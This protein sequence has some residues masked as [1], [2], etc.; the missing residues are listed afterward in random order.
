MTAVAVAR[1]FVNDAKSKIVSSV[2]GSA[3]AG[4]PSSPGSPASLREPKAWWKTIL[5]PCPIT[6]TAPGSLCAAIASFIS[7]DTVANSGA[8]AASGSGEPVTKSG[9]GAAAGACVARALSLTAVGAT[10]PREQAAA[11]V[12][13][14]APTAMAFRTDDLPNIN[15]SGLH[16]SFIVETSTAQAM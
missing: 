13:K 8:G 2:I 5:P 12:S 11:S 7:F 3:G 14:T 15:R 9:A 10:L 6:T 4:D 16:A 1:H